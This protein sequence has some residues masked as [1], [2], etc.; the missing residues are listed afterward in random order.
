MIT[1]VRN[2]PGVGDEEVTLIE[3]IVNEEFHS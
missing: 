3:G 2:G 1:R